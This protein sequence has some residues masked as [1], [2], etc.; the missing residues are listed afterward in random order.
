MERVKRRRSVSLESPLIAVQMTKD[1]KPEDPEE[2]KRITEAGGIVRRLMNPEGRNVGPWRVWQKN[3]NHPGLAMSRSIGDIIGHEIGVSNSPT[4]SMYRRVPESDSFIIAGTDGI[5]DVM[6]NQEA[7][8]YV[9]AYRDSSL[10]GTKTPSEEKCQPA[11]TCI[12]QLLCEEAR[13]RWLFVVEEEDV[14]I[15]D[16]SCVVLELKDSDV[17]YVLPP[18]RTSVPNMDGGDVE[19]VN[20]ASIPASEVRLRDPRRNSMND[21]E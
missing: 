8:D 1:H 14:L 12:A 10:R 6:E 13:A 7:V 19:G 16:I 3:T 18:D 11:N 4:V 21:D 20:Y 9:E 15:D 2:L 17:H 5:W